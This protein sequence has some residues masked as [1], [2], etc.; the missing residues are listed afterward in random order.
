MGVGEGVDPGS[1]DVD[2]KVGIGVFVGESGVL[3]LIEVS[4]GI[5]D[6]V[7]CRAGG[8]ALPFSGP[9]L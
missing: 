7:R 6:A 9:G 5:A 3:V 1:R 4:V 8:A 2:V